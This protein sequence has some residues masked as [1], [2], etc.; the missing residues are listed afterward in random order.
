MDMLYCGDNNMKKLA[1]ITAKYKMSTIV[2]HVHGM[3]QDAVWFEIST[4]LRKMDSETQILYITNKKYGAKSTE[5][6]L[7]GKGLD[8]RKTGKDYSGQRAYEISRG[9]AN[10]HAVAVVPVMQFSYNSVQYE[11]VTQRSHFSRRGLDSGSRALLNE[12]LSNKV[13]LALNPTIADLGAGWGAL[14][15]VVA[16][17]VPESVIVAIENNTGS[18]YDLTQ[19]VLKFKNIIPLS[20]DV[21][22]PSVAMNAYMGQCDSII[23]NPPFHVSDAAK[24]LFIENAAKLLATD[25]KAY[26]VCEKHFVR[27]F[28]TM[29][30]K[31]F[32]D[33]RTIQYESMYVLI[34]QHKK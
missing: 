22:A 28:T 10:L 30:E 31:H 24:E 3:T 11:V 21:T 9:H 7:R 8:I 13:E 33:V 34:C 14:S 15:L 17:E 4:L 1:N 16:T 20:A 25:G 18:F 5:A 19:N 23:S 2:Q 27:R 29:A 32:K 6:Y 26:L 12:L